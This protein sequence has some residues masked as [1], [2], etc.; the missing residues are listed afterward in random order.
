MPNDDQTPASP[1]RPSRFRRRV[2]MAAIVVEYARF[3][4]VRQRRARIA[5]ELTHPRP[6]A[7]AAIST[8]VSGRDHR[9]EGGVPNTDATV[10]RGS[11]DVR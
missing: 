10:T 7:Q 5:E 4:E 2:R 9:V 11:T 1:G 6:E 8:S 3:I